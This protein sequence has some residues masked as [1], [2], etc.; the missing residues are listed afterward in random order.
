ME[1]EAADHARALLAR[2]GPHAVWDVVVTANLNA[3]AKGSVDQIEHWRLVQVELVRIAPRP[4]PSDLDVV[5][6]AQVLLAT[7]TPKEAWRH[8]MARAAELE[9]D[10]I[11]QSVMLR[12][13]DAV[14]MLSLE[15]PTDPSTRH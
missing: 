7:Q 4:G 8:A 11:G 2:H 5:R 6:S 13:A 9:G 15:Q 1:P 12:I 14:T 3:L 10:L